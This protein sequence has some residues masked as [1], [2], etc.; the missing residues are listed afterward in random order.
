[1]NQPIP[2]PPPPPGI[3]PHGN[4]WVPWP[5]KYTVQVTCKWTVAVCVCGAGSNEMHYEH[6]M[7]FQTL[8]LGNSFIMTKK[9]K[10][11]KKRRP[12]PYIVLLYE[13]FNML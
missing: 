10:K 6:Y 8:S 3:L 1:M 4:F 13:Q 2:P 11:K 7:E 12:F 5:S 9:K